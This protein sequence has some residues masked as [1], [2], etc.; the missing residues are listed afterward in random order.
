M[1]EL[2]V[3]PLSGL[4]LAAFLA[5]V[6]LELESVVLEL[7]SVVLELELEASLELVFPISPSSIWG[8]REK[9]GGCSS[10]EL[11]GVGSVDWGVCR[12]GLQRLSGEESSQHSPTAIQQGL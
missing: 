8:N 12:E 4:V 3:Y 10:I 9:A 1:W 7:E 11:E 6:V 5:T 2:E